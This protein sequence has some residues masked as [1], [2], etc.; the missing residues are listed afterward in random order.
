MTYCTSC[1]PDHVMKML[2]TWNIFILRVEHPYVVRKLEKS[3]IMCEL[4]FHAK[5]LHVTDCSSKPKC[6]FEL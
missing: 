3:L 5:K 2:Y 1:T 4:T 6:T